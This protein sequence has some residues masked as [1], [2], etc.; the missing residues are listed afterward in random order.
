MVNAWRAWDL[1]G[2]LAANVLYLFLLTGSVV[3]VFCVWT[4]LSDAVF[5]ARAGP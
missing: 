2:P 5:W 4:W 3:V 1:H